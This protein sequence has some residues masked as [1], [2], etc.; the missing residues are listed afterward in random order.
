[1]MILNRNPLEARGPPCV[2]APRADGFGRMIGGN[3]RAIVLNPTAA[4]GQVGF[5]RR[6][7]SHQAVVRD[8]RGTPFTGQ[9]G[10]PCGPESSFC[11]ACTRSGCPVLGKV[12]MVVDAAGAVQTARVVLIED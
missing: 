8:R 7:A 6:H 12:A 11:R 3:G 9:A 5:R 1:M 4:P 10:P 2:I